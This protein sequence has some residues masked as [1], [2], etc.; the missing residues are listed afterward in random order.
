MRSTVTATRSSARIEARQ[1]PHLPGWTVPTGNNDERRLMQVLLAHLQVAE[2]INDARLYRFLFQESEAINNDLKSVKVFR[3]IRA[4]LGTFQVPFLQYDAANRK[5]LY[6][7]DFTLTGMTVWRDQTREQLDRMSSDNDTVDDELVAEDDDTI[8]TENAP[9]DLP[10]GQTPMGPLPPTH[11]VPDAPMDA[12]PQQLYTDGTTTDVDHTLGGTASAP[13]VR[14]PPVEQATR[15]PSGGTADAATRTPSGGTADAAFRHHGGTVYVPAVRSPPVAPTLMTPSSAKADAVIRHSGGIASV[16]S[17]RPPPVEQV[18]T[19]APSAAPSPTS[20][21]KGS[22]S[23]LATHWSGPPPA[24]TH[25]ESVPADTPSEQATTDDVEQSPPLLQELSTPRQS[26]SPQ[27]FKSPPPKTDPQTGRIHPSVLSVQMQRMVAEL[28]DQTEWYEGDPP[29]PPPAQAL[30]PSHRDTID[31]TTPS[32]EVDSTMRRPHV[33][34]ARFRTSTPSSPDLTGAAA[35]HRMADAHPSTPAIRSPYDSSSSVAQLSRF[36]IMMDSTLDTM[37]EHA[38][39][40]E[41]AAME[42]HRLRMERSQEAIRAAIQNALDQITQESSILHG[43]HQ[44]ELQ[45]LRDQTAQQSIEMREQTA[46]QLTE[47]REQTAA[48]LSETVTQLTAQVEQL[49]TQVTSRLYNG[50]LAAPQESGDSQATKPAP[51][52]V[53]PPTTMTE[54]AD[55]TPTPA[56]TRPNPTSRWRNVNLDFMN[57][58]PDRAPPPDYDRNHGSPTLDS[59]EIDRY[60]LKLRNTNTPTVLRTVDRKAVIKFYNAFAD[61]LQ[62]YKVPIKTFDQ[63]RIIHLDDPDIAVYPDTL[64]PGTPLYTKYTTAVYARLEE[65][66]VLDVNEHQYL[67]LL[68]M[69]SRSRDGYN[70][71]KGLLAA[72]LMTDA[73]NIAQLCT[74][75]PADST[76]HPYEYA[77]QL[78]EF[79]QYQTKFDRPYT[80]REQALMFLQGM[81]HVSRF[82]SAAVQLLHDLDQCPPTSSLPTRFILHH[83]P[84]TLASHPAALASTSST[85]PTGSYAPARLNVTRAQSPAVDRQGAPDRNGPRRYPPRRFGGNPLRQQKDTQCPAC[86]TYGHEVGECRILPKVAACLTYIKEHAP[87]VQTTLQRYKDQQHPSTRQSTKD[88]LVQAVYGHLGGD[89]SDALEG[90]IEHLTDSLCGPTRIPDNMAEQYDGNIFHLQAQFEDY[91]ATEDMIEAI[92]PVKFPLLDQIQRGIPSPSTPVPPSSATSVPLPPIQPTNPSSSPCITLSVTTVQQRDLADTGASVSATGMLEIL[93]N[94]TPH[95]RYEITGYDGQ[96]TRA[97]GEGYAHV[98]NDALSTVDKI[99]FVYS[100]TITGTIFSLEHHAQTHSHTRM[101]LMGSWSI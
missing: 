13:A 22:A 100:P 55:T 16:P 41:D 35:S 95:T 50:T 78:D 60:L 1:G 64:H 71:L 51:T 11:I 101:P 84:I 86:F 99:L 66:Q 72:T 73:K 6:W 45:R 43:T 17:G 57:S 8:A 63:L 46:T 89:D 12:A 15:T 5:W 9:P 75:P 24:T 74:P 92:H 82:T 53:P 39:A 62:Q 80:Q 70:L 54:P 29:T 25:P 7:N 36:Q 21:S 18:L 34:D 94:F 4:K 20:Y 26:A 98:H 28:T 37:T 59:G 81:S 31:L 48:Q 10:D 14:S 65:D 76:A 96:V 49:R 30:T 68:T 44:S 32:P 42:R 23:C 88:M 56:D 87:L 58:T 27:W 3:R 83:I 79:F 67:G 97:A 2:D 85:L 33:L 91:L 47:L 52:L 69:Y 38:R 40:L 19:T 90:L 93:H 77:S 61:F